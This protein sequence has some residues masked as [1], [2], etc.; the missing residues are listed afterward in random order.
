MPTLFASWEGQRRGLRGTPAT[1]QELAA[2]VR[3]AYGWSA[4]ALL[5]FSWMDEDNDTI[6]MSADSEV[7]ETIEIAS[8]S[9][10]PLIIHVSASG[11]L[12]IVH[13]PEG[14]CEVEDWLVVYDYHSTYVAPGLQEQVAQQEQKERAVAAQKA[15]ESRTRTPS[16]CP[17]GQKRGV[18]REAVIAQCGA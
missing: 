15:A 4:D 6:Q 13:P 12:S 16:D 9:G 3:N 5:Q 8:K 7:V 1:V 18:A 11:D 14:D 2:A 17:D 10:T